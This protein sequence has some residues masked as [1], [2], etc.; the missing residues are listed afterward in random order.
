MRIPYVIDNIEHQLGGVL[1]GLLRS[2]PVD[3]LDIATAY[4]SI[5]GY[6]QLR[7]SLPQLRK[8]RLLLG[9]EPTSA[10]DIGT[11][12]DSREYLRRELNAAPLTFDTQLLV[13]ELIRFLRRNEVEVRL[14]LMTPARRVGN[15]SYTPSA[16][17]STEA[18]MKT[19]CSTTST[20]WSGSSAAAI[21]PDR[22]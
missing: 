8:P 18:A 14:Y 3:E 17:C 16:T 19:P 6:Q 13:E 10:D 20:R 22:G 11:Q 4:F 7:H 21:S 15:G 2:G 12:P 1:D 9:D 5:R